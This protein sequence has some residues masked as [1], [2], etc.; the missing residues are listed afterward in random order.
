MKIKINNY[1]KIANNLAKINLGKTNLNPSVGC[2][3]VKGNSVISSGFTSINGRPHAEFNALNKNKNFLNSDLYVTMEPCTHFGQTPPCTNIIIKKKIKRVFF[4]NYDIDKRTKHKASPELLKK[5]IKVK[6]I[7][8]S[9]F[10]DFYQSY[11]ISKNKYIPLIDAKLAVSNDYFTIYKK[12]WITNLFSRKRAHLIRSEYNAIISTSKSI[13]ADNSKLNCRLNGFNNLKPDLI[14]ID[15]NMKLKKNL[16]IFKNNK[17]KI[18]IITK[19]H[20]YRNISFFK[21]KNIKL[22][23]LNSLKSK[24]D[25]I[26]LFMK[27]KTFGYQRILVES[28]VIFIN[29]LIKINLISNLYLFKASIKLGKKGKNNA[30][31]SVIKKIK[32]QNKIRVN[33][34]G[35]NLYKLKLNNV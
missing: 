18:I 17:R 24:S 23:Y 12:K 15:L 21:K 8:D 1:F 20:K 4:S 27:L 10:K 7:N 34:K 31:I 3:I 29:S 25:F 28:G 9:S 6:K 22:I 13:N 33:L 2:V 16:V 5:K 11:Y 14:I 32:L 26:E 19:N 35:D 30:S